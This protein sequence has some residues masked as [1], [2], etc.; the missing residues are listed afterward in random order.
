MT[1]RLR[2]SLLAIPVVLVMGYFFILHTAWGLALALRITAFYLPG[3][4]SVD[5][6]HGS[7][8]GPL[9][10]TNI[11]YRHGDL[12]LSIASLN[13][14]WRSAAL[15][16]GKLA[17]TTLD[18]R[19][20]TVDLPAAGKQA[21]QT[22]IN[23]V[24]PLAIDV[25]QAQ[26]DRLVIRR[27][28]SET[29]LLFDN[30]QL[31]VTVKA[32]DIRIRDLRVNGYQAQLRS[33]GSISLAPGFPLDLQV[34]TAYQLPDMQ[35]INGAGTLRGDLHKLRL[36][37]MLSGPLVADLDFTASDIDADL[38][39]EGELAIGQLN[40][41]IFD[42]ALPDVMI[43]GQL[44]PAGDL[45]TFG[46]H[47]NVQID[48]AQAG[49]V[50]IT[51]EAQSD[52]KLT[53][54]QFNVQGDFTGLD[55]PAAEF[56]FAGTG[57]RR[58]VILSKLT[59]N[60][61]QGSIQGD[62]NIAWHPQLLVN[63]GL[64]VR[65]IDT[66]YFD[67][68][69]PGKL[70]AQLSI[71][72]TQ[73]DGD[74]RINFALSEMQ[75]VLRDYPLTGRAQGTWH[76]NALT[77][78]TLQLSVGESRLLAHGTL[79]DR[80]DMQ[81]SITAP[82]V[83]NL[84]PDAGGRLVVQGHVRGLRAT[85]G[86][87]LQGEATQ[88]RYAEYAVERFVLAAELGLAAQDRL[89]IDLQAAGLDTPAGH[90]Q[91]LAVK[92]DG[93]A[94]D[95]ELTIEA[96]NQ[97]TILHMA[98]QGAVSAWRWQGS[99]QELALDQTGLGKWQLRK[100]AQFVLSQAA[101]SLSPMCLEQALAYLCTELHWQAQQPRASLEARHIPLGLLNPWLPAN[102]RTQGLINLHGKLHGGNPRH[103]NA[104]LDITSAGDVLAIDFVELGERLSLG[105]GK[106]H[107]VLDNKGLQ[108]DLDIPF[109]EGGGVEAQ[110]DLPGW[111]MTK[112]VQRNQQLRAKLTLD[113]LPADVVTRFIPDMARAQGYLEAHLSLNGTLGEP[114]LAGSAHWRDGSMFIPA[115]GVRVEKISAELVSEKTNIASFIITA[116]SGEGKVI[117][118]GQTKLDPAQGWPSQGKLRST[119]LE[120]MNTAEAYILVDADVDVT[121]QGQTIEIT[122]DVTVPRAR[123]QPRVLP[124]GT[125]TLSQ[126]VIIV[127]ETEQLQTQTP[128]L[129]TSRIRVRLG[130]R[131]DFDGFGVSGK[132]RGNL[133]VIDE[134][135]RPVVGQGELSIDEGVYRLRGQD[136]EIRRGRLIFASSFIDNPGIDV[137]A[138]RRIEPVL[139]GVRLKGTLKQPTLTIFSEPPM[140]E[141]DALSYLVLGYA[142]GQSST[143]EGESMRNTAAAMGFVAGD[144]LA[145]DIGGQLGLDELRVD[146]GETAQQTSLVMGKY[147]S[148]RLYV[149]YLTGIVES[150]N[151]VQLRYQ[152]SPRVQIQTEGGYRGSQ[153]VTGGDIFFTIQY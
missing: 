91:R 78:D 6:S 25:E 45:H 92:A 118:S 26:L 76:S 99:L 72:T 152:L 14:D 21:K 66:A 98:A 65:N 43:K 8:S 153:S 47:G 88:L 114:R 30:I 146:V 55:L 134:P 77:L 37:Q 49:R 15:L 31:A 83:Q 125:E 135:G 20:V 54:Y 10:L 71:R 110:L 24:L 74:T 131:V 40:P 34:A 128:W 144:L 138:T 147:L 11:Q 103:L 1:R 84:L 61:L 115:L 117:L 95:H 16:G 63:A 133:L 109:T 7:L 149:R 2:Y 46:L 59:M 13:I 140:A 102:I 17:I 33:S 81:F 122:G 111:F 38:R 5:G 93:T 145:R 42:T 4:F 106:L 150:S 94:A 27:H 89:H 79:D 68:D 18:I 107:A 124:E 129:V 32:Q 148:S 53:A 44:S 119:N 137:E 136:L 132:L 57:T 48:D 64:H 116:H 127:D 22:P 9:T 126:D 120:V 58:D 35:T 52:I 143:A 23:I 28:G 104:E 97:Q 39:W 29:P 62:A 130:E 56:E 142:Y 60:T 51:L 139:V 12:K 36:Q 3:E 123:L 101:T 80:W 151:I 141:A 108:A 70:N 87:Q 85:P 96:V 82:D 67:R 50:E 75:G 19:E 105:A 121:V 100:P 69:W 73:Q 112:G 113:K 86:L 90:W 41:S